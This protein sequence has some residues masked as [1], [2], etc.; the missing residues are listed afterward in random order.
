[1]YALSRAFLC[2]PLSVS[3]RVLSDIE[4]LPA[5]AQN[6]NHKQNCFVLFVAVWKMGQQCNPAFCC[7]CCNPECR[8]Q[9]CLPQC[10]IMPMRWK[11]LTFSEGQTAL[12]V[13]GS[14][15]T[16][17]KICENR[18]TPAHKINHTS[19]SI[20]LHAV[21]PKK[22][23]SCMKRVMTPYLLSSVL[24]DYVDYVFSMAHINKTYRCKTRLY[25][26]LLYTVTVM[27]FVLWHASCDFIG[28]IIQYS[29][30]S[31]SL[32]SLHFLGI[33]QTWK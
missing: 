13:F 9:S 6:Y 20:T 10:I 12:I 30:L 3:T 14:R 32:T 16:L 7:T 1:M 33:L 26:V 19:C 4:V 11:D 27:K 25:F 18:K 5:S 28:L 21:L 17:V 31:L 2:E 15:K 29:F 24:F 22:P 8:V 23:I